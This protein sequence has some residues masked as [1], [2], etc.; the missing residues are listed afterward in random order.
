MTSRCRTK[1]D[2][3]YFNDQVVGGLPPGDSEVT[4]D[5]V[6]EFDRNQTLRNSQV[7]AGLQCIDRNGWSR[8]KSEYLNLVD[9]LSTEIFE[10]PRGVGCQYSSLIP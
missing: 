2:E 6:L 9:S 10:Q 7:E 4:A 3:F 1:I 8:K 5:V